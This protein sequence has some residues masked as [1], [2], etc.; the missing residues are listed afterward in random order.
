LRFSAIKY[1]IKVASFA[2]FAKPLRLGEKLQAKTGSRKARQEDAKAAKKRLNQPN[3]L[4][5][6]VQLAIAIEKQS[7]TN[8][9]EYKPL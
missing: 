8:H 3:C 7:V 5:R 1:D 4:R 6:Q 2:S 9:F